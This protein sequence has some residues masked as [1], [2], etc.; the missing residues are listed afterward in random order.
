MMTLML[1]IL[2]PGCK[3]KETA[4]V[5]EHN[6]RLLS[7]I[8][9]AGYAGTLATISGYWFSETAS[10]ISVEVG[11]VKAQ[12]VS[13]TIDRINII[14]PEKALGNYSVNVSVGG[15]SVEGLNFRYAEALEEEVLKIYSYTPSSGVEG[16]E[17]SISGVCFSNKADRN[18][19]TIN[20]KQATVLSATD[21]KLTVALPDNPQ[22]QY[23]FVVTVDGKTAEGPMFT[24][25]KKPE[26]TVTAIAPSFGPAGTE[27]TVT[28]TCFSAV[29][30][31]NTVTLNGVQAT[32]TS[33][34]ATELKVT[35]PDNPLGT[36]AV[37][38][39]V[40]GKSVDGPDF[41]YIPVQK[42]Y[43]VKTISGTAGRASSSTDIVDGGSS[44]AKWRNPRGICFLPDGRL[45]IID[46]GTN[47]I[48]FMNVSDYTVT[49]T[50]TATSL[51]NAPWRATLLGDYLYIPSKGNGKVIRYDY[52]QDKAEAIIS[53]F[54]GKSPMD[55]RFDKSGNAYLIV[56]DNKAIYKYANADFSKKTTFAT[57]T[58]L[59]L[60][61]DFDASGNLIVTTDGCQIVKITSDGTQTVI[62]GVHAAKAVDDGEA[63][64]PLA[65][66]FGA[67]MFGFTFDASGNLYIADGSAVR[68]LTLGTNGY[69]DATVTTVAGSATGGTPKDGVGSA[70][71]FNSL[72]DLAFNSTWD[73]LYV[74]EYNNWIVREISI[75]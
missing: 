33:A 45:V 52:K 34:T 54:S 55:M 12:V 3:D 62:A 7:I 46:S 47:T 35:V 66:K 42:T 44:V 59:P 25:L 61:M 58:D 60:A 5:E 21:T 57:F 4:I 8:P 9:K 56:R 32:V 53:E 19:V 23:P 22:G 24:Y 64:K 6:P 70:A 30:L 50:K 73:K 29:P 75:K 68:M 16:D 49:T 51:F 17:I 74:T 13:S 65:A 67:N 18:A 28:G 48:R 11:G 43:T 26:L 36:Y 10:D 15:K 71:V 72:F 2:L 27:I 37:K 69:E 63:G 31:E 20:G 14:M 38:V 40:G 41:T 1:T 39:T